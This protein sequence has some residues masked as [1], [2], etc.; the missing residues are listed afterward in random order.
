MTTHG[1]CSMFLIKVEPGKKAYRYDIDIT[2]S[3]GINLAKGSDEY[4]NF[5]ENNR[6]FIFN[7]KLDLV[8]RR[9]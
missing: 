7:P 6:W 9:R 2:D 8:D 1:I 3:K 4:D 5:I